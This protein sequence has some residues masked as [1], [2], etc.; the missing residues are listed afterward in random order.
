[1]SE[2]FVPALLVLVAILIEF[3]LAGLTVLK[4]AIH[5]VPWVF[6]VENFNEPLVN[7]NPATGVYIRHF[8]DKLRGTLNSFVNIKN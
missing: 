5:H 4:I 3:L 7:R 6:T 1:M 8:F 2:R